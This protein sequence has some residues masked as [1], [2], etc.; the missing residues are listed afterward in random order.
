[1]V[2]P[3]GTGAEAHLGCQQRN[4]IPARNLP[5]INAR[6][7]QIRAVPEMVYPRGTGAEAH[8]GCHTNASLKAC[9]STV[10]DTVTMEP[11]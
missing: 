3:R 7:G 11:L 8:L 6:R 10:V 2:Y 4:L 1:M 5:P 9:S